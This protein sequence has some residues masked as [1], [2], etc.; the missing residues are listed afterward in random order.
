MIQSQI[1][2]KLSTLGEKESDGM[3][4]DLLARLYT[5]FQSFDSYLESNEFVGAAASSR[6]MV[7]YSYLI[8]CDIESLDQSTYWIEQIAGRN[9][10]CYSG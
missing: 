2:A 9:I 8:S 7:R 6:E 4:V 5:E 3:Y 1:N 10:G